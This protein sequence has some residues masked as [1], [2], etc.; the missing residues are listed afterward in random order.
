MECEHSVPENVPSQRLDAYIAANV[1]K[2]AISRHRIT[3]ALRSGALRVDGQQVAPHRHVRPHSRITGTVPPDEEAIIEVQD[4]PSVRILFTHQDFYFVYKPAGVVTHGA[5]SV[6]SR[7]TLVSALLA[8][9]PDLA[10]VGEGP[11]RGGIVHRLDRETAGVMVVAR[12][13]SALVRLQEAFQCRRVH[14]TYHALLHGRVPWTTRT[15]TW[16]IARST[17]GGRM[18]AIRST[19]TPYRGTAREAMTTFVVHRRYPNVTQVVVYPQTGRTHQIR[20]HAAALGHAI[21]G[22]TVYR[23]RTP[24][25]AGLALRAVALRM[26]YEGHVYT[27]AIPDDV[28]NLCYTDI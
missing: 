18:V 10:V 1:Y 21:V 22:D 12:S 3:Q 7:E 4:N 24:T 15:V 25:N 20:V 13:A 9:D 14:K 27:A 28:A 19:R 17:R 16:P 26:M 11:R 23:R 6:D 2:G 8:R 5:P